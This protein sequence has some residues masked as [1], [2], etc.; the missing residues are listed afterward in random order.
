MSSLVHV[1]ASPDTYSPPPLVNPGDPPTDSVYVHPNRWSSRK[2]SLREEGGLNRPIVSLSVKKFVLERG[3]RV[4]N[5]T[6]T[7]D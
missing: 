2:E 3:V 6:L 7:Y 1:L 4:V 5:E